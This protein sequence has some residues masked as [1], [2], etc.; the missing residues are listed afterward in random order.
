MQEQSKTSTLKRRNRKK[1]RDLTIIGFFGCFI[2]ASHQNCAPAPGAIGATNS[3]S[4]RPSN[5]TVIDDVKADSAV[6]FAAKEIQ[7]NSQLREVS[8]QGICSENQ[9][10]ATLAWEVR[11]Q[12]ADEADVFATGFA[13]CDGGKFQVELAPTQLLECDKA[14]VVKARLGQGEQGVSVLTRACPF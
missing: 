7:L 11:K 3:A 2:I 5:V 14:Y 9:Q 6:S 12:G 1:W 13:R 4:Q 10:D 8:L